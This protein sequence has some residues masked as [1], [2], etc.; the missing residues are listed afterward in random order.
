M[1]AA[2]LPASGW[3]TARRRHGGGDHDRPAQ[4]MALRAFP[5]EV[6][7]VRPRQCGTTPSMSSSADRFSAK[8]HADIPKSGTSEDA[9]D[10]AGGARRGR[11]A[12]PREMTWRD[13]LAR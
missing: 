5:G 11:E 1:F 10:P 8:A 9:K 12:L 7:P 2:G 3:S 6:D 4:R 13:D